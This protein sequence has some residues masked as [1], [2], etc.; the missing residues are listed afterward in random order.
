MPVDQTILTPVI[1]SEIT[2]VSCA[3]AIANSIL[4]QGRVNRD[5]VFLGRANEQTFLVIYGL[6]LEDGVLLNTH[7]ISASLME[8]CVEAHIAFDSKSEADIEPWFNGFG[9]ADIAPN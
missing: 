1:N 9:E 7:I 3:T 2:P 5:D 6:P 8:H 4:S